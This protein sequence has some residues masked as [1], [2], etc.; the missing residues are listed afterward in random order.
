M[1]KIALSII[2]ILSLSL[3]VLGQ[4]ITDSTFIHN[5]ILNGVQNCGFILEGEVIAEE[6]YFNSAGDYIYTSSTVEVHQTWKSSELSFENGQLI[7]VI[8]RGGI[9]GNSS[10]SISHQIGLHTEQKGLFMLEYGSYPSN[11][12]STI[13]TAYH[14]KLHDGLYFDYDYSQHYI[15][16]SFASINF[17]CIDLLYELIDT[18]YVVE[19]MQII[20]NGGLQSTTYN[21][22]DL[23]AQ[24]K[25]QSAAAGTGTV[26]YTFENAKTTNSAGKN[27]FEFDIYIYSS[28]SVFFDNGLARIEFDTQAFGSNIVANNK[29]TVQRGKVV[30]SI[31]DYFTPAPSDMSTNEIAIAINADTSLLA[32]YPIG[33]T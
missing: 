27:F 15:T 25:A 29:I 23:I 30:A 12:N 17:E 19:C 10:L 11:P 16:T 24:S 9:V 5:Q 33:S 22:L 8:T 20:P 7:E 1:N 18:N 3:S 6:S 21:Q 32:R 31:T 28:N 2:G 13:S 26:T 14:F 4:I